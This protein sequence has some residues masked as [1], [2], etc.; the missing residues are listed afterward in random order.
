MPGLAERITKDL[1]ES[2]QSNKENEFFPQP[3]V[4]KENSR[5]ISKWVGMSMISSMSAFDKFFI[6]KKQYGENGDDR[7]AILAK[8]F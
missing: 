1:Y 2:N 3:R 4:I 8:I 6:D 5:V 7:T